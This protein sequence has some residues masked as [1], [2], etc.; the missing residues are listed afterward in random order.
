[1]SCNIIIYIIVGIVVLKKYLFYTTG[2]NRQS[3]SRIFP[4]RDTFFSG[5]VAEFPCVLV[6]II[7][8]LP[9]RRFAFYHTAL[10]LHF[11]KIGLA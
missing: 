6:P 1:M 7:S 3:E 5:P 10:L 9:N 8:Y 4:S 11:C 2:M